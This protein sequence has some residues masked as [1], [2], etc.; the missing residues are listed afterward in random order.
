LRIFSARVY[1]V[2]D[3]FLI[4][5]VYRNAKTFDFGSFV[6]E[7]AE[8]LFE[9][10][11]DGMK[12]VRGET[13]PGYDPHGPLLNGNNGYSFLNEDHRLMVESLSPGPGL[14]DLNGAVL[15]RVAGSLND[16]DSNGER[17]GLYKWMRDIITI[18]S[19]EAIYGEKNPFSNSPDLVDCLWYVGI[20]WTQ[21]R[22]T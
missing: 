18:A 3:P 7:S 5:A 20:T 6:V 10:S 17:F 21:R 13:A 14:L 4:Q 9:I 22:G 16:I 8:R 19:A 2:C 11:Q 12:I 15:G 1:V